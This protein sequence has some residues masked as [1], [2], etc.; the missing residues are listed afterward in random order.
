MKN[1]LHDIIFRVNIQQWNYNLLLYS[2]LIFLLMVVFCLIMSAYWTQ[3]FSHK[4]AWQ[5]CVNWVQIG[6][7]VIYIYFT[8]IYIAVVSIYTGGLILIFIIQILSNILIIFNEMWM[9]LFELFQIF[10]VPAGAE[11]ANIQMLGGPGGTAWILTPFELYIKGARSWIY[12]TTEYHQFIHDKIVLHQLKQINSNYKHIEL[13][14]IPNFDDY[15]R[16]HYLIGSQGSEA[17]LNQRF[18]KGVLKQYYQLFLDTED[19]D[20]SKWS[21]VPDTV[22]FNKDNNTMSTVQ[23]KSTLGDN[24]NDFNDLKFFKKFNRSTH[25]MSI[26]LKNPDKYADLIEVINKNPH[27]FDIWVRVGDGCIDN[28]LLENMKEMNREFMIEQG[29]DILRTFYPALYNKDYS[30]LQVDENFL[31][32]FYKCMK[33]YDS[34]NLTTLIKNTKSDI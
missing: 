8:Q 31:Q 29:D 27:D 26:L 15:A 12:N 21:G 24:F 28:Y 23:Y 17:D 34:Q 33:F 13:M 32:D 6:P 25:I 9:W 20:C 7:Y 19:T 11:L 14:H 2:I 4:F 16:F 3:I 18:P 1:T 5:H 30:K 22:F 10:K